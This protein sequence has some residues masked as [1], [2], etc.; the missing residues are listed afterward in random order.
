[1]RQNKE[2]AFKICHTCGKE[3]DRNG[4]CW[5]CVP[6]VVVAREKELIASLSKEQL[7]LFRRYKGVKEKWTSMIILD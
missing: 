4:E 6:R 5:K 2:N 3:R 7:G 1:M